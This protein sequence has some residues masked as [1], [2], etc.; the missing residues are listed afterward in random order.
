MLS[1]LYNVIFGTN[2]SDLY[3]QAD[4]VITIVDGVRID[5]LDQDYSTRSVYYAFFNKTKEEV[6]QSIM[7]EPSHT[8][9]KIY[10]DT[11]PKN[12]PLKKFYYPTD[13]HSIDTAGFAVSINHSPFLYQS[14]DLKKDAN[15][16]GSGIVGIYT[17]EHTIEGIDETIIRQVELIQEGEG[18]ERGGALVIKGLIETVYNTHQLNNLL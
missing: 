4:R 13:Q 14:Y 16:A 9:K 18:D 15:G 5:S 1:Y 11:I 12:I 8:Y 7:I 17:W 3:L 10:Y 2:P 6:I